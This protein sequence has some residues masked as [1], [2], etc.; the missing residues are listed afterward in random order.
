[1]LT[2]AIENLFND[3]LI[4]FKNYNLDNVVKCYHL[5]CTLNTPDK[6]LFLTSIDAC[7]QEFTDIFAQLKEANTS[8][9][10]AHKA[11]YALITE[12][13]LLASI[14]WAFIDE[15]GEIF[16]DFCAIYHLALVENELKIIN[17]VSHDLSNSLT[18]AHEFKLTV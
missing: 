8:K 1:M 4:A 16:A 9:I 7:R 5:P 12:D 13:L 10:I 18:L 11:S 14:D 6:V 15:Q 3:Y 2:L 17:V